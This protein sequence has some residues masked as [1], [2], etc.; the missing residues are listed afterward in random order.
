MY[1]LGVMLVDFILSFLE[2]IIIVIGIASSGS[3][4]GSKY[5]KHRNFVWGIL[6]GIGTIYTMQNSI[7][8]EPGRFIDFRYLTMTLA[9]FFGGFVP[10]MVAACI[11]GFYRWSQGGAGSWTGVITIFIFA[12]IGFYLRK[13]KIENW[14]FKQHVLLG[15]SLTTVVIIILLIVPPWSPSALQVTTKVAVPLFLLVPIGSYICFKIFFILQDAIENQ[16]LLREE[17]RL[18]DLDPETTIIRNMEGVITFWNRKA[19]ELYGWTKDEAIGKYIQEILSPQFP[20]PFEEINQI[21]VNKGRWEGELIH[22]RKDGGKIIC[23]SCWLL[24]NTPGSYSVMELNLD[25]TETKR[26]EEE[27][28]RLE[29]LNTVG[30]MAA[31]ISHE[32]RNPMTTVRGY[33]QLFLRKEDFGNYYRQIQTMIDELDRA[34]S[35]ITEFLSLAKDK[36]SEIK[37]DSLNEIIHVLSPLLQ[38]DAFRMGHEIQFKTSNIPDIPMDKNEIRQLILNLT[39]NGFEAMTSCGKIMIQTYLEGENVVL[40]IQDTGTGIPEEVLRKLGTPFVTTKENGTGIGLSVCYRI[41][42]RH[43]AKIT[44]NSSPEGTTFFIKFS[45]L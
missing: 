32:V 11:S 13:F 16:M 27:L 6:L 23:R 21:L 15:G 1:L 39:R 33:L 37:S 22:T 20:E 2:N 3:Y 5:P 24:K 35:I 12:M 17:I 44:A 25:I 30:E 28:T 4:I 18:L 26:M 8:I 10:A 40:T 43:N 42:Q 7:L 36:V 38:A 14:A 45:T 31:G 19:E 9:G 29:T 34:N 41:A